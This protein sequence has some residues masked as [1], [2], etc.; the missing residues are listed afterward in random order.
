MPMENNTR[1]DP[2]GRSRLHAAAIAGDSVAVE[3]VLAAG[4][5]VSATDV[6][7]ATALHLAGQQ[8]HIEVARLLVTAGAPVNARDSYGNTPL[9]RAVFAFQ[10]GEPELIRLLLDAGADPEEKNN[11]ERSPRDLAMTFQRPGIEAV[12][13]L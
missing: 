10:G 11:S 1:P 6:A 3:S 4:A 2:Q 8:S 9:W 5:D 12:F 13:P 7:G